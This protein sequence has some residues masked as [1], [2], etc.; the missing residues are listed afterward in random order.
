MKIQE[1]DSNIVRLINKIGIAVL[2]TGTAILF[3][4][5]GKNDIA[6]IQAFA[7][8]DNLPIQEATNFET[9]STD[10]GQ[11]RY[12]MKAPKLLRYETEGQSFFEFPEG[13]KI[14][15]Y[16]NQKKIISTLE[17]DYAKQFVKEDRWEA[18]NN[19]VVT[20]IQGDSLKTEHLILDEKSEEIYTEEYVKII[21]NDQEITG[22]GLTSD[23]DMLNWKIKKPRGIFY[24]TTNT[25]QNPARDSLAEQ[26]PPD[27]VFRKPEESNKALQFK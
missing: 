1:S 17:A 11:I 26:A 25:K 16:N 18:K 10:S 22:I 24:V 23:L 7:S 14:V 5:C 2:I 19:V 9:L 27:T 20:N 12:S 21:R 3:F 4:A 6:K 13:I 8:N 15:K